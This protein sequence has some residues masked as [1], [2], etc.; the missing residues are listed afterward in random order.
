MNFILEHKSGLWLTL[1]YFIFQIPALLMKIIPFAILM[2]VLMSLSFLSKHN[3]L[4]AMRSVGVSVFLLVVPIFFMGVFICGASFVFNEIVVPEANQRVRHTKRVEIEKQPAESVNR[5][6]HN[7]TMVGFNNQIYFIGT[8]DGAANTMRDVLILDFRPGAHLKSR[9]DAKSA[10]YENGQWVFMDGY[11]RAF[12]ESDNEITAKAFDRMN[13]DLP[14]KPGD[15]LK[16]QKEPQELNFAEL[17]VYVRQLKRNGSDCHK[18]LVDLYAKTALPFGC[19]ILAVLGIPWG[20]NMR[21]YSGIAISFGVCLL[22][23]FFYLGGMEIG[24]GLGKQGFLSPFLATWLMNLLYAVIGPVLL[25][26]KN[27]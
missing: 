27:R 13:V 21:K 11:L 1:K 9:L 19:V 2:S 12:N 4:L 22:A 3:E 5:T 25:I 7:I 18:E 23:A 8:F 20:W 26:W 10:K 16:E 24:Q 17:L 14:E 15:F 6:R